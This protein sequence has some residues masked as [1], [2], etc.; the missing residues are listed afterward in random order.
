MLCCLSLSRLSFSCFFFFFFNDTA[1]TEIYTLSLHDALP[2]SCLVSGFFFC[3]VSGLIHRLRGCLG[4]NGRLRLSRRCCLRLFRLIRLGRGDLRCDG[5]GKLFIESFGLLLCGLQA[6]VE[7]LGLTVE[8]RH[9]PVQSP[10]RPQNPESKNRS[11]NQDKAYG[12]R[13]KGLSRPRTRPALP[14]GKSVVSVL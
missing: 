1:T 4:R 10:D 9:L 13:S 8:M 12:D 3:L 2:I 14:L 6:A 7:L 5:L 11:K